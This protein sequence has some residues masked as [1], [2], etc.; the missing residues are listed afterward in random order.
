M[1]EVKIFRLSTG[2][3]VIGQK[4]E[5]NTIESTQI[6]QPFV[7]VPMQSKPGGPISLALT[8][9]SPY[10]DEDTVT[11]KNNNIVTEVNPKVDIKKFL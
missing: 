10:A 5:N 8:P 6:K 3:D 1:S 4:L 7:I 11:I 2:E 9:Y